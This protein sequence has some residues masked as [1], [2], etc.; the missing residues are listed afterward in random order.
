MKRKSKAELVLEIYDREAMG[1]V[2]EREIAIINRGLIEEYGAGG[3]LSPAEIAS[4]LIDEDLPV[5]FDEVFNMNTPDERYE[6]IFSPGIDT[7]TLT[8][9][10]T[11]LKRLHNNLTVLGHQ[12]DRRGQD[13]ARELVIEARQ[14]A[15]RDAASVTLST[16]RRAELKE[17]SEWLGIWLQTPDLFEIWLELRKATAEFRERFPPA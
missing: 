9:A 5:R 1:E 2:T 17:I 16:R 12:N 13:Y 10:E 7:A 15:V 11:S 6:E 3:I 4:I 14:S 8:S